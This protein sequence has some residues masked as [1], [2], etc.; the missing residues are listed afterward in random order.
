MDRSR[1]PK[2]EWRIGIAETATGTVIQTLSVPENIIGR[3]VR[4][5]PDGTSIVYAKSNGNVGNLWRQPLDGGPPV[6][7]TDFDSQTI[8][9]FAWSRDGRQIAIT[10]STRSRDAV[11]LSAK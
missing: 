10:R 6:Q 8:G 9:D 4:W 11:L 3:V 5:T 7:I 1:T 2:G